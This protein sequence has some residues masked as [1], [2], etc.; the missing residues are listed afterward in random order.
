MFINTARLAWAF[1]IKEDPKNPVDIRKPSLSSLAACHADIRS[2]LRLEPFQMHSRQAFSLRPSPTRVSL[3]LVT[4]ASGRCWMRKWSRLKQS[5]SSTR[6]SRGRTAPLGASIGLD[7]LL[8]RCVVMRNYVHQLS[9]LVTSDDSS[10]RRLSFAV[11][12]ILL[13]I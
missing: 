6:I 9:K 1:N 12:P 5:L 13:H 8:L 11:F 7:P 3:H 2:G 4:L 10:P